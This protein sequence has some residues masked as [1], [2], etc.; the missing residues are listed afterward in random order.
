M[1]TGRARFI[2]MDVNINQL[3]S[4]VDQR[5]I[6]SGEEYASAKQRELY[7]PFDMGEDWMCDYKCSA[8]LYEVDVNCVATVEQREREERRNGGAC[9]GPIE[10][11]AQLRG[12]YSIPPGSATVGDHRS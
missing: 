9:S 12:F 1:K 7:A 6:S 5:L 4:S 11:R 3:T 2:D 8:R 10:S